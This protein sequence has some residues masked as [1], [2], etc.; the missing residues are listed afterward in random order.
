MGLKKPRRRL[1]P[2]ISIRWWDALVSRFFRERIRDITPGDSRP[3]RHPWNCEL[4][5]D[6]VGKVWRVEIEPGYC[7][8]PSGTVAVLATVPAGDAPEETRERLGLSTTD[9]DPVEVPLSELPQIPLPAER[10]RAVGTESVGLPNQPGEAAPA[11]F[12]RQGVASPSQ[13]VETGGGLAEAFTGDLTARSQARL[14]RAVDIVLRHGRR[15]VFYPASLDGLSGTVSYTATL[16]P[17]PFDGGATVEVQTRYVPAAEQGV[18]GE[19]TG[20]ALDR[21][22][23]ET[24][25][26]TLYL[27]SP[28]GT[29]PGSPLDETWTP[30]AKHAKFWDLEYVVKYRPPAPISPPITF[31]VTGL[32]L[33]TLEQNVRPIIDALNANQ[34][35]AEAILAQAG[36]AGRFY[37]LA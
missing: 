7:L 15:R 26:A 32:G 18:L 11:Y 37:T 10:W 21:G 1:G 31:P 3:W 28:P 34:A 36:A 12:R 25:I 13:L 22:Y 2:E 35:L 5:W 16:L 33:G 30:A 23:D 19:L 17:P 24:L 27:M 6:A 4:T 20:S 8:S 14:L 29:P 9:E